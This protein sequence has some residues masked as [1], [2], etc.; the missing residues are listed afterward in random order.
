[1]NGKEMDDVEEEE[2]KKYT[3]GPFHYH[4]PNELRMHKHLARG[5]IISF[6]SEDHFIASVILY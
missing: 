5:K 2:K 4:T 6:V 1:M 3:S